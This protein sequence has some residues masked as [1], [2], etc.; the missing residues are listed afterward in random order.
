M[1]V[2]MNLN[3]LHPRQAV[4]AA[5]DK[6]SIGTA[7]G[8][9]LLAAIVWL[10]QRFIVAG[11]VD[12]QTAAFAV[13]S[14]YVRF[15][16]LVVIVFILGLLLNRTAAK[17]KFAALFSALSLIQV[18]WIAGYVLSIIAFF[19]IAQPVAVGWEAGE[20]SLIAGMKAYSAVEVS[21]Q[22]INLGVFAA[23]LVIAGA[24]GLYG[25]YLVYL[26]VRRFASVGFWGGLLAAIVATAVSGIL[27]F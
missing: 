8:L 11:A 16:L 19:L 22:Q 3:I 24:I 12:L 13:L 27:L 23:F 10:A 14:S 4:D 20:S 7:L 21:L 1:L 25:L 17:G 26:A 9:V 5:F 6:P 18:L 15:F 2:L